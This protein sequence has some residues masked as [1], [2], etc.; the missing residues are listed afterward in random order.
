MASRLFHGSRPSK[1]RDKEEESV[2][3]LTRTAKRSSLIPSASAASKI[4]THVSM[5]SRHKAKP[6][7]EKAPAPKQATIQQHRAVEQ[8]SGSIPIAVASDATMARGRGDFGFG[9]RTEISGSTPS[10]KSTPAPRNRLRRKASSSGQRMHYARSNASTSIDDSAPATTIE[11]SSSPG[12]YTDPFP[13]SILGIS[14]PAV[15]QSTSQ[16][17]A[18]KS[19][20]TAYATSSSRMANYVQ[21]PPPSKTPVNDLTPPIPHYAARSSSTSTRYSESPGPFSRTSTPTSASSYSPGITQSSRL[22]PRLKTSTSPTRSR[23]PVTKRKIGV[24]APPEAAVEDQGLPPLR[25]SSSSSSTV[26]SP[27][28][29]EKLDAGRVGRSGRIHAPPPTPPLRLSSKR[30]P[31]PRGVGQGSSADEKDG[32]APR[33]RQPESTPQPSVVGSRNPASIASRSRIPPPRPSREGT[34]RLENETF[35]L[36]IQSNL[37]H[38]E[39]TGHKRR[40][41][42]EKALLTSPSKSDDRGVKALLQRSPSN[43]STSSKRP[44]TSPGP[45]R[46]QSPHLYSRS[47]SQSREQLPLQTANLKQ[48]P[49]KSATPIGESPSK[50]PSRFGLFNRRIKSPADASIATIDRPVKKGPAAGTGHEGYGKYARRGRSG[51]I[52]TTASRGRSTSTDR[53]SISYRPSSSRKS[54]FASED[55]PELDDFYR[56]RLEPVVI[57]GGGAIRENR[58]SRTELYRPSS[59]ESSASLTSAV[60]FGPP[61]TMRTQLQTDSLSFGENNLQPSQRDLMPPPRFGMSSRSQ[62]SDSSML[63]H[64][65]SLHRSQLREAE[66]LKVPAPINTHALDSSAV[67]DSFDTM[68][69]SVAKT[70]SSLNLTDDLPEGHEG[71]WLRPKKPQQRVKLP[72]KW[73]FF[74]RAQNSPGK[75]VIP[76]SPQRMDGSKELPA[77]ISKLPQS[78]FVPHYAMMDNSE[79]EDTDTLEDILHDIEDDLD[80]R[81]PENALGA[82][83]D[84]PQREREYS[85]LLPSPPRFP[86]GFAQFQRPPPP[87]VNLDQRMPTVEPTLPQTSLAPGKRLQQVGRIPKV[88]S[89]R[90][91]LHRPPPQSFSRPFVRNPDDI[92]SPIASEPAAE[93]GPL[94]DQPIR[95]VQT[96]P[97]PSGPWA[98][99]P[100]NE[101]AYPPPTNGMLY[102]LDGEKE[103]LS[104]SPRQN[105]DVSGSSSSGVLSFAGMAAQMP[106]PNSLLKEDEVWNEYDELLDRVTSPDSIETSWPG[107]EDIIDSFPTADASQQLPGG[108]RKKGSPVFLSPRSSDSTALASSPPKRQPMKGR[109]GRLGPVDLSSPQRPDLIPSTPMSFSDIYA[110]YGDRSSLGVTNRQSASSGSRYSSQSVVSKSGSRT[111]Q[112][113]DSIKRY[114]KVMA[115]KING[116]V[117]TSNSLRYSALMTARWLCF[118]R[119]LFSPVQDEIRNSRQDK[120]LVLDGLAND[121]WS[122]YCAL[123]YP[124]ATVYNLSAPRPLSSSKRDNENWQPPP[125]HRQ[126]HHSSLAHPFP[127][128][129]GFF[130]A[131]VL[132]FPVATSE[133]SLRSAVSECKRV[134]RPGGYLEL[135]ILDMDMVNMGNRARRA[136]RG[137]KVKMQVADPS[138]SLSP[139]SDTVQKMLGRRGFENLSRCV[140]GVPVAGIMTEHG[141]ESP[142][143]KHTSLGEMLRD[144]AAGGSVPVTKMIAKVGRWWWSR[145]YERSV[146]A[147]GDAEA[148]IWADKALLRECENRDTGFRL[149]ICHAQKPLNVRRR[150]VSV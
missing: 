75:T 83:Q 69:S 27:G 6:A 43:A 131:V 94:V 105:S 56:D 88:V 133:P 38:L 98:R 28:R 46:Q 111:S 14:L 101:P 9:V 87:V 144:P 121:D 58:N 49:S 18:I 30:I 90:D 72:K 138:I 29:I 71:N 117:G 106:R 116:A 26:K 23:P 59:G 60:S 147:D 12:G 8:K 76:D 68:R 64:R 146:V 125:N 113:G 5:F 139:T 51:S 80:L 130:T 95:G 128:P 20:P 103:F 50:S 108:R 15:S 73:N 52:S 97:L 37:S 109:S 7:E 65:R 3:K 112:D 34:P 31:K 33:G 142:D 104:F 92:I 13:G 54:S 2:G 40:E 57:G 39:T 55:K 11:T 137:L 86:T 134:L 66:P 145:C 91:R 74:Q 136:V 4:P 84:M 61:L 82:G 120:V 10:T 150:T 32:P 127:F 126:I 99:N 102:N 79:P 118:D 25:E 93:I 123:T 35:S 16:I 1:Q 149:V 78:R 48:Y 45:A 129:K 81:N 62:S 119:V 115:D 89:K 122:S 19:T 124:D 132:R 70:D 140:V 36:V 47:K 114:T 21:R 24:V 41:S 63:A 53:T 107:K 67:L 148:S 143:E 22:T 110:G 44:Q 17:P 135:C 96:E 42:V 141:S 85:M 100:F 77:S